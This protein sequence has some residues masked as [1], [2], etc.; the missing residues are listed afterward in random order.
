MTIKGEGSADQY[1]TNPLRAPEPSYPYE[2]DL[3]LGDY[4]AVVWRWRWTIVALC[5]AAMLVAMILSIK[6]PRV[7]EAQVTMMLPAQ[8]GG[9]SLAGLFG[10]SGGGSMLQGMLGGG[11]AS[12]AYQTIL[13]LLESRTMAEEIVKDFDLMTQFGTATVHSAAGRLQGMTEIDSDKG[14]ITIAVEADNPKLAADLANHYVTS[15]D[16][17][18]QSMNLTSAKRNRI[19]VE[20]RLTDNLKELRRTEDDIKKFQ[21]DN[22][23]VFLD[24]QMEGAMGEAKDIQARMSKIEVTLKVRGASL[25]PEHPELMRLQIELVQLQKRL[26]QIEMGPAGKGLLPGD[27]LYPAWISVPDLAV[28]LRHYNR[29]LEIK[30]EVYLL[31]TTQLEQSKIEEIKDDPTTQL[32]D[33][34]LPPDEP[35]NMPLQTAV[36]FAGVVAFLLGVFLSFFLDYVM[37]PAWRQKGTVG[38]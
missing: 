29:E 7:Y 20:E 35:S 31:L 16:R 34:A 33:R 11:G 14:V 22:M 4:L 37:G 8:T 10:N 23:A 26:K 38:S 28:E 17:L 30:E 5:V 27:R 13:A 36:L 32:L 21:L 12:S 1:Q 15:L 2:D 6:A 25:Q 9:V 18:N 24:S 3:S 19:F